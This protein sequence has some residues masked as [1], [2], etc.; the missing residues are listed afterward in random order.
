[1]KAHQYLIFLTSFLL[2]LAIRILQR[3]GALGRCRTFTTFEMTW[4]LCRILLGFLIAMACLALLN[5][6]S[7]AKASSN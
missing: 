6:G 5:S 1:M 3:C 7:K 2:A 4:L